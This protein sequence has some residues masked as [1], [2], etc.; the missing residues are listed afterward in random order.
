MSSHGIKA[1]PALSKSTSYE[2]WLKELEI[3]QAFTDLSI[4]KQGPAIFLTLEGKAREAALELEVKNISGKEGVKNIT[5]KLDTL[6]KKDIAQV[7]YEAYDKFE[8]FQ[9]PADMSMKDFVIEFERL[10]SKTRSHGTAMSEDILAYRLLRSANISEHHQQLARATIGELK[11]DAMKSQ[12]M[13]IFGD[14]SSDM[15]SHE[16]SIKVESINEATNF[17]CETFYGNY[18]RRGSNQLQRFSNQRGNSYRGGRSTGGTNMNRG[19]YRPKRGRNP[20]NDRGMPSRCSVCDSVNHWAANCPDALYYS[21]ECDESS[22]EHHITLYQSALIAESSMKVF[23]AESL[24]AAILDSGA[25]STVCGK[26]WV[27]CYMEGLSSHDQ[28]LVICSDSSNCFKFGSGNIFKSLY[29]A[30]LPAVIGN[31]QIYIETDVIES[32]IPMLLSK[33]AMKRADTKINF[34]D[35]TV[36]MFGFKQNVIVTSSGHYAVP[37]NKNSEVLKSVVSN[38]A[39]IVLHAEL[40][41]DDK[42]KMARKLHAQFSHPEQSKL[43]QLIKNAGMGNNAELVAGIR[44]VSETCKICQEYKRPSPRPVVGLPLATKFNEVVAMDLKMIDDQ[45]VLHLIDHVSRFSAAS[46]VSSKKPEEIVHKIFDKWISV[47]GP[48]TKFLCDN[49]GEFNSEEFR[50]FCERMNIVIKTTAAESPWSNGLCERH[51]AILSDVYQKTMAESKCSKKTALCWAIHSKNSLA[52][53]HGFSP[54][55]LAIGYT[56][57][58]PNVLSNKLPANEDFSTSGY[59]SEILQSMS[60]ARKAFIQSENSERIKRALRHNVRPSS[61]N[62]YFTGDSVYY[63]RNDARKWKGP[64]KVIGYDAQQIL[65]KHGSV[66]VRV[67]PCRVLLERNNTETDCDDSSISLQEHQHNSSP[68]GN[69]SDVQSSESEE[70]DISNPL[71]EIASASGSV[72]SEANNE[73]SKVSEPPLLRQETESNISDKEKAASNNPKLKRGMN[74]DF[75]NDDGQWISGRVLGRAGKSTGKYSAHWNVE[76]FD[77]N[78]VE[79]LNFDQISNWKEV[80][81]S[82][83]VYVSYNFPQIFLTEIN[84]ELEAAKEIELKNWMLEKVY[85]EVLDEGQ[86]YIS[87]RWVV[88]PKIVDGEWRTKARLVAR[89]F[90]EDSSQFRSDSP[91]CTKD[92]I[93]ILL[94]VAS[95]FGWKINSMDIKAAFLQGKAIDREVFLRPPKEANAKGKLWKLRKVVYGLSDASR[96]WYLRVAEELSKLGAKVSSYDRAVF[97]MKDETKL[98]G[99]IIVH[100]DDFLWVGSEEFLNTVMDPIR[101]QFKVSKEFDAAFKYVGINLEQDQKGIRLHQYQYIEGIQPIEIEESETVDLDRFVTEKEKKDFRTLVGQM[102]WSVTISRP[103]M[104]FSSC[105]L[106]TV[107]SKPTLSD[108]KKANKYLKDMKGDNV[109]LR[110]CHLDLSS[111]K[112]T[113]YADASYGNLR[114][115]GSQGG[116]IIFLSDRYGRCSPMSWCSKRI[117]RVA[118]STLSAETQAA[119]EALDASYLLKK[120]LSEIVDAD[121]EVTLYTDNKSLIDAINTTNLTTDKRLRVDLAALREMFENDEVKFKWI[122]TKKQLADI[123]TKKGASKQNL[124]Q[125]LQQCCLV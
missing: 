123:L 98:H 116:Y 55:Q 46:F 87:C 36:N 71:P 25:S 104:A 54:Y 22:S 65:I 37:L 124:L 125:I 9:R 100:V 111:A 120:S 32:E 85:E 103:D 89:G 40:M 76:R 59:L 34:K 48:P 102:Q 99:L 74:I 42:L 10:V 49:G 33:S 107:Q 53:V 110:F 96:V 78:V 92:S 28:N 17:E 47:F 5:T 94:T 31:H 57:N 84:T 44:K 114:D 82:E 38:Q 70:E 67:H 23:V 121:L 112:L 51:N 119:V 93:R 63:K 15:T 122:E 61:N 39:S 7:A 8:R 91:T 35:D 19:T 21:E 4:E 113:V 26:V 29:K 72:E 60:A 90:E 95:S 41:N 11:Y 45:W 2:T 79:E 43:I 24:S 6:Y 88:T 109:S 58:L 62:K 56:P 66:Y 73:E 30:K 115:G 16:T 97:I 108:L 80:E 77:N 20:L 86:S 117:R 1:P 101:K 3:W 106:G 68:P 52:N 13:K 118:R 64:G 83:K 12:L 75:R 105:D 18:P 27:D 81:E 14:Q 69:E 50:I